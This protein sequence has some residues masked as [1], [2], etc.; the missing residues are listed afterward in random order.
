M[1]LPLASSLGGDGE[2]LQ[3]EHPQWITAISSTGTSAKWHLGGYG[4]S[5]QT[6]SGL[7]IFFEALDPEGQ[8]SMW[9]KRE[10]LVSTR[11]GLRGGR[12]PVLCY[13]FITIIAEMNN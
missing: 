6:G 3:D 1:C 4:V 2:H 5:K 8:D 10:E 11:G 9:W 13:A 12:I 7:L